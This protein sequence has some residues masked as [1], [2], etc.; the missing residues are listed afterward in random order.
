MKDY[1]FLLKVLA[2]FAYALVN[3]ITCSAVWNSAPGAFIS[4]VALVL[5][6]ADGYVVY[7]AVKEI[8]GD[9]EE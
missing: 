8:K 5:L 3:I 6:L 4:V 7:R 1:K 9:P 2:I